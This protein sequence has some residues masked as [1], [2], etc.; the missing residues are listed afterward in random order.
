MTDDPRHEV[1]AAPRSGEV[2]A[3]KRDESAETRLI[4]AFAALVRSASTTERSSVP[5][6]EPLLSIAD[7]ARY[8]NISTTTTRNLAVGAKIRST[9]IGDRIRF[10]RA[11]LDEWID[12][13]GGDV[14]PPPA[15]TP[16]PAPERPPPRLTPRP[17]RPR[18]APKPK[19]PTCI[20][21]IGDRELRLLAD[22]TLDRVSTWHVGVQAPLCGT[23]GRWTGSLERVPR[24]FLC[25]K[26]LTTLAA[27]PEADLERFGA[28][29]V[30]M[31]R[32]TVRGETATAMRSGYHEGNGRRTLCGK[33]EGRWALTEREP[34]SKQCFVCDHRVR[35]D[36]RDRDSNWLVPRPM[37]PLR[38]LVDAGQS[39]PRLIEL[40]AR[41]PTALDARRVSEPLPE[42]ADINPSKW[43]V[44]F[45]RAEP[46]GSFKGP[47][48][49]TTYEAGSW[50]TYTI[51]EQPSAG[52][53]LSDLMLQRL[54][55]WAQEIEQASVL[56]ARWAKESQRRRRR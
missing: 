39:D 52:T 4:E 45:G 35:W 41:H 19:P 44:A 29:R 55:K 9:R 26:C 56:Y 28:G 32:M 43:A 1:G 42:H 5:A 13:G 54:E 31:M 51:S 34:R 40:V 22:K 18:P 7:A 23:T 49:G 48:A 46:L 3:D 25:P 36:N 53:P 16:H 6:P 37:T 17:T 33:S 15:A 21:R 2:V 50:A 20:Q 47:P 11:W 8:L 12:A 24:A 30:F 14:P 27:S 10:R 38:I